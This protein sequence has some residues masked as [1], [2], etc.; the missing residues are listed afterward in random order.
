L[1]VER[2]ESERYFKHRTVKKTRVLTFNGGVLPMNI[3]RGQT[4]KYIIKGTIK[5]LNLF[6]KDGGDINETIVKLKQ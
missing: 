4:H 5:M 2:E 1:I 3:K 6:T